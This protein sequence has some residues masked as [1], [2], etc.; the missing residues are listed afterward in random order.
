MQ[1][2]TCRIQT[3]RTS[4]Q[5]L[6]HAGMENRRWGEDGKCTFCGKL[7]KKQEGFNTHICR[8]KYQK[9]G[10]PKEAAVNKAPDELTEAVRVALAEG[11]AGELKA[12]EAL[13]EGRVDA[14]ALVAAAGLEVKDRIERTK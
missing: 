12:L 14:A 4:S 7:C 1:C 6:Q 9:G 3:A 10:L 2:D 13:G 5:P 11:F 8:D